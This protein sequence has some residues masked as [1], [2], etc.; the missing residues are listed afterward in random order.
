M[1]SYRAMYEMLVTMEKEYNPIVELAKCGYHHD[2]KI[3]CKSYP[4]MSELMET[5]DKEN[6]GLMTAIE[7]GACT[8]SYAGLFSLMHSRFTTNTYEYMRRIY[9]RYN[10]LYS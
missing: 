10:Y 2:I 9:N 7:N 4:K 3:V 1:H 5:I 8:D 6:E